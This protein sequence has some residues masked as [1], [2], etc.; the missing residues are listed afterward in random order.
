[1]S[2]ERAGERRARVLLV[3]DNKVNRMVAMQMLKRA[4]VDGVEAQSGPEALE[5]LRSE[6]FDLV[7]MDIQMPEMDGLEVARAIRVGDAGKQNSA[8]PIIAMT[9]YSTAED[10]EAC[11]AAGMNG[12]LAKPLSMQRFIDTVQSMVKD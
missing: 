8:V 4:E 7:L 10:E 12:Y 9:A 2:S 5:K 6:P 11:L 1:M 3:E